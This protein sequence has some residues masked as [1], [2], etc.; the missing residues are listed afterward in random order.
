MIK[1]VRIGSTTNH[2]FSECGI[3]DV[4]VCLLALVPVKLM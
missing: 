4:F 2:N 3:L 1:V